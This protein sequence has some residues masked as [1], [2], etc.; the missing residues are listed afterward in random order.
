MIQNPID[1][2]ETGSHP[3]ASNDK[4]IADRTLVNSWVLIRDFKPYIQA[5]RDKFP[6]IPADANT[7][8][9]YVYIDHDAGISMKVECLCTI[10]SRN[11]PIAAVLLL[12]DIVSLK[13]R[14]SALK[15]L[16]LYP[17]IPGQVQD[18]GISPVPVWLKF[19]ETPDLTPIRSLTWLDP[20]RAHG[21]FDDV[22]AVLPGTGGDV[23]ELIWVRL[24]RYSEDTDRFSGTLLNEPF[25]D[26]GIHRNDTI[27]VQVT[28]NSDGITL[29]AKPPQ[30]S[31]E[32]TLPGNSPG[33]GGA[34]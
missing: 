23:P 19:Y 4:S 33:T 6:Q 25:R 30:V 22:M 32:K 20:F 11:D 16:T 34:P 17:F 9:G 12:E 31:P 21:F 10:W 15:N 7:G 24:Q 27:E 5:L 29:V 26:Y 18:L 14:Y 2:P 13:L 1:P 3:I 8:I 28:R